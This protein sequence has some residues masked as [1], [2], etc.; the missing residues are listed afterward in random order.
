MIEMDTLVALAKEVGFTQAAPL[1]PATITLKQEVR[2]MCANNTCGQYGKRWSCPP[3][4]GELVRTS[5]TLFLIL[6]TI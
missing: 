6:N 5:L 4:C 1:D 2:D 3:G